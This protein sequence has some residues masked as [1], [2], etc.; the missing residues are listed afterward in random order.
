MEKQLEEINLRLRQL[1]ALQ[2]IDYVDSGGLAASDKIPADI[3][4][5]DNFFKRQRMKEK[6]FIEYYRKELESA[7]EALNHICTK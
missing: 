4:D 2:M 6:T 5:F 3:S 1:V 7:T